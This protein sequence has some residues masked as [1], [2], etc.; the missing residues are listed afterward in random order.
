VSNALAIAGVTAVLRDLL[1]SGVI[2]HEITDAMGQGVL[3]SAVAPDSIALEGSNA[4]P[5]I[6][7]FLHQ[8]T[9]NAALRNLDLPSRNRNGQ[10][11]GNPPLALDLH[12]LVTAYGTGDLQAEVLL[13]Y[14][15]ML[16]HQTPLPARETIRNALN[17]PGM[18]VDG[19][20]LPSVYQA[21]RAS[22]LSEQYE[23]I[24]ISPVQMNSEEMSRIWSAMQAP[25]RPTAAYQVSVVLIES[26]RPAMSP[27]PVLTRGPREPSALDPGKQRERGILAQ[28]G[29]MLAYP[30]IDA[31]QLPGSRTAAH[32][33][34]SIAVLGRHLD[35]SDHVLLL[36]LPRLGL[37]HRFEPATSVS[38]QR[39]EFDLPDAP[40][41]IP[42]GNY[43]VTMQLVRP[44]E[45]GARTSSEGWLQIAPELTSLTTPP[46]VINRDG[47]LRA[48]VPVTCRP[49]VRPNQR[50]SLL[51]GGREIVAEP[52]ASPTAS[53]VFLIE[54]APVGLHQVRLRVDGVDS[55]MVDRS[56]S[57]P[58]F[59][60]HRIEI[61]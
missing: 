11:V 32:L 23:Q 31:L 26:K 58:V 42:A 16:L 13:G 54:D 7:I 25:Y 43:L 49:Q 36:S 57:P 46:E 60:D 22:D 8:V 56:V 37:E 38:A 59:R 41:D 47:N 2:D 33:G 24:R 14:A 12:Y 50:A 27:L 35:G 9:H 48:T 15:M 21:L 18:P 44:G 30:Q 40:A 5:Q 39:V 55:Q 45:S 29:L 3:V 10:R 6:N 52:H 19:A 61:A 53:L 1:D 20:L 28:P 4:K 51:L 34:D 17:P